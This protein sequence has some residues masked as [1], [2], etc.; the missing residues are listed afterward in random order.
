MLK[1]DVCRIF[2]LPVR[3]T[4]QKTASLLHCLDRHCTPLVTALLMIAGIIFFIP[5]KLSL[6][7]QPLELL[8]LEEQGFARLNPPRLCSCRSKNTYWSCE[9]NNIT[10]H[11]KV[12]KKAEMRLI[13][14]NNEPVPVAVFTI[15][16]IGL[17]YQQIEPIYFQVNYPKETASLICSYLVENKEVLVHGM[18]R[19]KYSKDSS[20]NKIQRYYLR[21][22]MVELLPVFNSPAKNG[23]KNG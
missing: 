13:N 7:L 15:V 4:G 14:I 19:Q 23:A 17:P 2:K 6:P 1:N 11:G 12:I 22:E 3:L 10:V 18:M 21:A 5:Q 8:V 20:G 16:D 9:M